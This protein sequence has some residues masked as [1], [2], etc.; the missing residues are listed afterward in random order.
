MKIK[1]KFVFNFTDED[2]LIN[3]INFNPYYQKIDSGADL[4]VRID[5]KKYLNLA[6]NNYLAL[7]NDKRIIASMKDSLDKYG[8]SMCGTPIAC[9]NVDIYEN[10]AVYISKFLSMEETIFYPSCY[11][12]NIAVFNTLA[13]VNDVIFVD[14]FAHSSL[15][16]GIRS[17]GCKIKPFRHNDPKHLENLIKNSNSYEN[18]F[19]VTESVF[20]TEGSI[21]P[22]DDIYE[23]CLKYDAVPV[24]DD[25]HGI[26]VIGATGKG[27]LE[28]KKITDYE[29][30]YTASTGKALGISGGIVS[31]SHNTINFLRYN[32]S[33]LIFSTAL[34][35]VLIAGTIKAFE[36]IE[37]EGE[38]LVS[39]LSR[40]KKYLYEHL[41]SCGFDLN[42]SEASV[43]SVRTGSNENTFKVCKYLFEKDI[44]TTP[45]IYPSVSK[46]KGIVRMI[47]RVDLDTD[48]LD[49]VINSFK[50]IN[51]EHPELFEK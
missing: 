43:C 27:I 51:I 40:N 34:P 31:S 49:H 41:Q 29:G 30:I 14:R 38:K 8:A 18:M 33:A 10:A 19:V 42:N 7:S 46:N 24:V 32:S 25:S 15:I 2:R 22:F 5:G 21:A 48:Q 47:P 9:G 26:G 4:Y 44:L 37:A 6:S 23:L 17:A 13:K 20:S 50:A 39:R 12:A 11:Q 45:F 1:D 35:P 28:E 36:I 3:E 16:E